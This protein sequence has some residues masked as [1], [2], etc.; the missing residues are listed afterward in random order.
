MPDD[1][2]ARPPAVLERPLYDPDR[3]VQ[4]DP[5]DAVHVARAFLLRCRAWGAEDE[6][7]KRLQALAADPTPARAASLHAWTSWV[8]FVDHAV[9]ELERGE[10]DHW[11]TDADGL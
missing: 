7:P 4:V 9:A 3:A 8:A 6:I 11:F 10:L 5:R 2:S 1:P